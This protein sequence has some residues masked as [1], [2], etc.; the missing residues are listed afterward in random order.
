MKGETETWR[1]IPGYQDRYEVSSF[2]RV[3]SW[4]NGR[5]GR[6]ELPVLRSQFIGSNGYPEVGLQDGS[7]KTNKLV[8]ELVLLAFVSERPHEH[9][10]CHADDVKTNN[11]VTNLRWRTRRDN[12]ADSVSNG[13]A[14]LNGPR[15][16]A[17][18]SRRDLSR[19]AT[20]IKNGKS[21]RAIAA[22]VGVSHSRISNI[23]NGKAYVGLLKEAAS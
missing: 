2:G 1:A 5:W 9:V 15:A 8:H 7:K 21:N 18:L 14:V 6:R 23:R 17:K 4:M 13:G 10:A 22:H 16:N 19:I 3:R 20:M 12:H 11:H